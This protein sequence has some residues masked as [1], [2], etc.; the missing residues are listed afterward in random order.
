[1]Q[2]SCCA[3]RPSYSHAKS[4]REV[5]EVLD[6]GRSCG[7][8][9]SLGYKT[10]WKK[11][12]IV[13]SLFLHIS[14]TRDR[15]I[16]W[17]N[18]SLVYLFDSHHYLSKWT[19]FLYDCFL[20]TQSKGKK[21]LIYFL[22]FTFWLEGYHQQRF[23]SNVPKHFALC[24]PLELEDG[25]LSFPQAGPVHMISV[26]WWRLRNASIYSP[27]RKLHLHISSHFH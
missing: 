19:P 10:W 16:S 2:P 6:L 8:L 13:S 22:I 24:I 18:I 15:K 27:K 23:V 17:W 20:A 12:D 3:L 5:L 4:S 1:V 26:S 11:L 14:L 25:A 9:D 7:T 21:P